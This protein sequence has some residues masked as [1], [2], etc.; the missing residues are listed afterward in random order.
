MLQHPTT[1][2]SKIPHVARR[3]ATDAPGADQSDAAEN[4]PGWSLPRTVALVTAASAVLWLTIVEL[5]RRLAGW[6]DVPAAF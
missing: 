3:V 2:T 5:S 1:P 6:L 4:L